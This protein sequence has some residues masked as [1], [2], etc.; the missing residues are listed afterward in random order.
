MGVRDGENTAEH[1]YTE[2]KSAAS[3]HDAR[4][5]ALTSPQT[6][7][8][9][10]CILRAPQGVPK[11]SCKRTAVLSML[12]CHGFI[13]SGHGATDGSRIM[14]PMHPAAR[15]SVLIVTPLVSRHSHAPDVPA[16]SMRCRG[17]GRCDAEMGRD[18]KAVEIIRDEKITRFLGVPTQSADLMIARVSMEN[19]FDTLDYLGS[20]GAKRA[21]RTSC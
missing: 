2:L 18:R 7:I 21:R 9:R 3:I 19:G 5:D 12:C 8:L 6:M 10:S 1:S 17:Q 20:G 11:A 14:I 13:H 4:P 15:P 16:Q